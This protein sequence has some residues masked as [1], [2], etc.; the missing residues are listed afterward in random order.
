MVVAAGLS[1]SLN[2]AYA[3]TSL[4]TNRPYAKA[5]K[6]ADPHVLYCEDFNFDLVTP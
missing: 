5:T 1:A 6:R 4:R 3:A 2:E